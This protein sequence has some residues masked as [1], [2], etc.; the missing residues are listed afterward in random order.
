MISCPQ[1]APS[2]HCFHPTD[3]T[4]VMPYVWKK[5]DPPKTLEE[6]YGDQVNCGTTMKYFQ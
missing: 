6:F 2:E 5:E 4:V 3:D 1:R